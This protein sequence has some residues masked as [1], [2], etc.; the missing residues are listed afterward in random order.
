MKG[1][2]Q[3]TFLLPCVAMKKLYFVYGAPSGSLM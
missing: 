1:S 2:S 3:S